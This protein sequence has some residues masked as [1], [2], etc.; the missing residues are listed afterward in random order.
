MDFR[1]RVPGHSGTDPNKGNKTGFWAD[2]NGH[3]FED[4][5]VGERGVYLDDM[6]KRLERLASK[7]RG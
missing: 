3:V 5:V 1:D 2:L 4:I 7:K 6:L